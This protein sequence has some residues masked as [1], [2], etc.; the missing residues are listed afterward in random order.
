MISR[1]I[2]LLPLLLSSCLEPVFARNTSAPPAPKITLAEEPKTSNFRLSEDEARELIQYLYYF[3]PEGTYRGKL[4][5]GAECVVEVAP[6]RVRYKDLNIYM[7]LSEGSDSKSTTLRFRV[8]T[9]SSIE[10]GLIDLYSHRLSVILASNGMD[11]RT[12]KN[13]QYSHF[14]LK[15]DD[16]L[17]IRSI[18]IFEESRVDQALSHA[19]CEIDSYKSPL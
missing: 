1:L 11:Y 5:N 7:K 17:N 15:F 14:T 18:Y 2:L 12:A 16:I 13:I 8:N 4:S 6:H 9:F 3:I 19:L 10:I